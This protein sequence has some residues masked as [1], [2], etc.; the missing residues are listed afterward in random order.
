MAD[1]DIQERRLFEIDYY[2]INIFNYYFYKGRKVITLVKEIDTKN[3][4]NIP[5]NKTRER[6]VFKE[7]IIKT[8][9][10]NTLVLLG[11][12]N[13][14]KV[15]PK[16]LIRNMLYDAFSYQNQT[17]NIERSKNNGK[18]KL[19]PVITLVIYY[20]DKEWTGPR[21]LYSM[22]DSFDESLKEYVPNYKL[23]IIK[24]GYD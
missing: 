9:D 8:S 3:V 4:V 7:A 5:E 21:D 10:K 18:I 2:F 1:K 11:I 12:E 24:K 17:I 19:K 22:F 6:D 14:T 20:S 15:D 23:N 16:M 13:Q